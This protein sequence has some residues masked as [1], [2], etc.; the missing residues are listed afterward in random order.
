MY[1]HRFDPL[2]AAFGVLFLL[3]GVPL[4]FTDLNLFA[5][6][7]SW[8]APILAIIVGLALLLT[9]IRRSDDETDDPTPML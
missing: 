3:I 1:R 7:W 8:G 9:G 2:S 5:I 6:R 4:L